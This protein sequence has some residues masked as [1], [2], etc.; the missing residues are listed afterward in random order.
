MRRGLGQVETEY[1][2]A[3][4]GDERDLTNILDRY[5][6][7]G[8]AALMEQPWYSHPAIKWGIGGGLLLG[9]ILIFVSRSRKRP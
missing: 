4:G 6:H 3:L 1:L 7:G 8:K 5:E 2:A 9:S